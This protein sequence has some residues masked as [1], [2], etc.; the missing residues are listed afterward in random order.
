MANSRVETIQSQKN[1]SAGLGDVLKP[2]SVQE[3]QA[4]QCVIAL[5]QIGNGVWGNDDPAVAQVLVNF[6]DAAVLPTFRT[7]ASKITH[8][9]THYIS[10][11]CRLA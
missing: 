9:L 5:Q 1:T 11:G 10:V 6:G 7:L 4:H 8:F 2:E 3:G